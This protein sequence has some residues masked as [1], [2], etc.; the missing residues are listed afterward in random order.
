MERRIFLKPPR[1]AVLYV[2]L[3]LLPRAADIIMLSYFLVVQHTVVLPT[4]GCEI[5]P[6]I[7]CTL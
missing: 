3:L 5:Y 4:I 2:L 7:G 1:L 6:I